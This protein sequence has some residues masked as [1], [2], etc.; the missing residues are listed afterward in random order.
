[1]NPKLRN[2]RTIIEQY[3]PACQQEERDQA[4]MLRFL[5]QNDDCLKRSNLTAHF[6]ASSWIVN[7]PRDKVLMVYHNIY[8][9]W[10]WTGGH[11][12]GEPDLM[13]VAVREAKEETGVRDLKLL[14]REP[15]SLE[16]ITVDGHEKRGSYVPSH[17]HL[18]LTYLLEAA[19]GQPLAVKE[20]ENS[21]VCW[22]PADSLA[23]W[24]SEPWMLAR[25]YA[26]LSRKVR[27][28]GMS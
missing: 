2:L 25:I 5:E 16:I 26:K 14:Q 19:E 7:P 23:D 6:T 11:A 8:D 9:S 24:V 27:L 3:R 12:D 17:L 13:S 18:N 21:G 4:V 1:M 28:T 22:I 10:S 20:D 15:V